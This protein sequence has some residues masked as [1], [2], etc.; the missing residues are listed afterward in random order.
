[1]SHLSNTDLLQ[2]LRAVE[3][4][5]SGTS[6]ETLADRSLKCVLSLIK[7]EMTAFDGFDT[8]G[9]YTGSYWYSPPGTVSEENVR[10]FGE[11]VHEHPYYQEAVL[12]KKEQVFRTS[13]YLSLSSFHHT[14]LYNEFYRGFDGQ[15]QI[16]SAMK[17]SPVS[18]VTCSIHRPSMD[19]TDR[20][21]EMLRLIT[22]HL[23]AAFA[24]AQAFE[25]V[26]SERKYLINV[27]RRGIAVMN[28]EGD[29]I[30]VSDIAE[31]FL[32]TYFPDCIPHGLPEDLRRHIQSQTNSANGQQYRASAEPFTIKN[33]ISE[34][35]IRL[36]FD[37]QA[38]QLTLIFE[39]KLERKKSDFCSLGLTA[40]ESEVLFWMGKGKTDGEIA[41]ICSVSL[42]TAQKHAENIFIKLGVETRT[43][44]VMAAIEK[45][46]D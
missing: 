12:T 19:F 43:S 22:P 14:T 29:L 2:I 42:R 17:V 8:E 25:I 15:A 36:S 9:N 3:L 34:L 44:A 21:L 6:M 35:I 4:L 27:V 11:L 46:G 26:D 13:D 41:D 16:T 1:M 32:Q 40:R 33:E 18:M 38:R 5:N 10:L 39:E 31:K 30:F 20:E 24:N 7:N 45:L 23:R 28:A 37:T